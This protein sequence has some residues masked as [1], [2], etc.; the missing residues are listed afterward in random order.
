MTTDR[1]DP[2]A[3]AA[4]GLRLFL[5]APFRLRTYTS[6]LYLLLAFPLGLAYFIFLAVGL[7]AGFGLTLVWIG[8]P[9]LAL[10]FAGSWG[11]A[12]FERQAAILLLGADVPPMLP[13]PSPAARTAWQRAGDFFSNPV[14]WKGMGFLLLKLPLGLVS[15]LSLVAT[16]SVSGAFLL[17]PLL[18]EMGIFD[19]GD[20]DGV[21]FSVDSIG[22][23]WVCAIAGL[24]MLFVSLNLL[25][26]LARI[27]RGTATVLL[28]S[29]RFEA[30][31]AQGIPEAV[32]VA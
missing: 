6:L 28:G 26:A 10:V 27:W 8:L 11:F 31:P 1:K 24:V 12:A 23:A 19:I 22:G 21:V 20:I 9:V 7:T 13:P 29:H 18:W 15:F 5:G 3:L 17:A 32:A 25:N 30:P 4:D 14:T 2:L 16:L